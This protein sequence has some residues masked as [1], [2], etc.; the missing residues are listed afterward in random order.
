MSLAADPGL[1]RVEE[2]I[3]GA[4][5]APVPAVLTGYFLL[6]EWAASDGEVY[7]VESRPEG[8]AYWRSL[9]LLEAARLSHAAAVRRIYEDDDE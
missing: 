6:T 9:G 7:L 2:A 1:A 5:L 4:D 8:Q 3:E